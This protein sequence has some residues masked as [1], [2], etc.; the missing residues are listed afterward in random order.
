MSLSLGLV[1][2]F[3]FVTVAL[4]GGSLGILRDDPAARDVRPIDYTDELSRALAEAEFEV[5]APAE[6]PNGWVSQSARTEVRPDQGTSVLLQIGFLTADE[7]YATV[8]QT[9]DEPSE[10]LE[11]YRLGE[12]IEAT[13][14]VAGRP[15][16]QHRRTD[17]D[18]IALVRT[19]GGRTVV[20]TGDASL[21]DLTDLAASL[22]PADSLPTQAPGAGAGEFTPVD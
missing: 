15:Y 5:V 9:D 19:E 18:E 7:R 16:E 20:V 10:V 4:L 3:V 2:L 11:A 12:E 17:R 6:V 13:V 21:A 22:R 1:I 8:A 14:D